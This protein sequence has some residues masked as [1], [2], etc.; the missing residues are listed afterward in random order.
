[1]NMSAYIKIKR[2]PYEEPYHLQLQLEASNGRQT[3]RFE[4]YAS[5]EIFL[6][7]AD[8]LEVF[9]RHATDVYLYELGS[10]RPEDRWAYYFRFRAFTTDTRG[11]C[12]IQLRFNNCRDLPHREIAEFCIEAEVAQI[13]R[14]GALFRS[15]AKLQEQVLFWSLREGHLATEECI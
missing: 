8:A 4:F 1:M 14:L 7:F 2:I 6:E 9:P 11:H 5:P 12:A 13:N 15:Y 10:E 3:A